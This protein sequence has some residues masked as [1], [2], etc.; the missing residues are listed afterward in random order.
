MITNRRLRCTA[1]LIVAC[2]ISS[3]CSRKSAGAWPNGPVR[4][5]TPFGPGGG[6]DGVARAMATLLSRRWAQP[7]TVENI[8]G[9][10]GILAVRTF[11]DQGGPHSLLLSSGGVYS[12]NPVLHPKLPYDP[13]KNLPPLTTVV[14]DTLA[15][16]SPSSLAASSL[17]QL[18][19][20]ART[21]PGSIS[22]TTA[23]GMPEYAFRTFTRRSGIDM[24]F[25]PY[26]NSIGSLP[27]LTS[28]RI[29]VA[30]LPLPAA[31]GQVRA[32]NLKVLAVQN[33]ERT[34]TLPDAPT[35]AEAGFPEL[36][37]D[38]GLLLFGRESMSSELRER[39][40]REVRQSLQDPA[41]LQQIRAMGYKPAGSTP[42]ETA[43]HLRN[44]RAR[45]QRML[46]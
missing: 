5:I 24:M 7:V 25:V 18:V 1:A 4:L 29:Q 20:L 28:G 26:R 38:G 22:Y 33:S 45:L 10:D 30:L 12:A 42:A 14:G 31:L 41:F 13:Q 16:L 23:P 6:S 21:K 40:S 17:T 32:G 19:D 11:L 43:E 15:F 39:L 46:K 35:V 34:P 37:A 36:T 3:N 27:D 44:L 8:P 9:A 2:V